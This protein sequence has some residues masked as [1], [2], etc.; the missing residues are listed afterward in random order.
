MTLSYR[1]G[2]E[3]KSLPCRFVFNSTT[4]TTYIV[5]D[6]AAQRAGESRFYRS[7]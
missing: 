5:C 7:T 2:S 6:I 4:G 3:A 1:V